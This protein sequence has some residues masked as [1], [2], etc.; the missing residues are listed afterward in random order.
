MYYDKEMSWSEIGE[1]LGKSKSS[2]QYMFKKYDI[3]PRTIGEA[4]RLENKSKVDLSVIRGRMKISFSQFGEQVQFPVAK[5][6][7]LLDNELGEVFSKNVHHKNNHP[8]DDRP[9]NLEVVDKGEHVIR[10]DGHP[11]PDPERVSE[12]MKE[13]AKDRERD[14]KGRFI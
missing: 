9:E 7:A 1:E 5:L 11:N 8:I 6:V 10:H 14:E 4:K 2:V 12:W 13:A 3:E